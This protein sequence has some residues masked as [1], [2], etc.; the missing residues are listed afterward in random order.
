MLPENTDLLRVFS[1]IIILRRRDVEGAIK[2]QP[3]SEALQ[4]Y[5]FIKHFNIIVYFTNS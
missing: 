1:K 4:H 3:Y 2:S 5:Y